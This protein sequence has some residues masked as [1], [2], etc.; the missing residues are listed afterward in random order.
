MRI[1]AA[2]D[3]LHARWEAPAERPSRH[4]G[5]DAAPP[6]EEKELPSGAGIEERSF[7]GDAAQ[8]KENS[9]G[10]GTCKSRGDPVSTAWTCL[11]LG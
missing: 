10:Q 8:H 7:L 9:L 5:G 1:W 11:V 4:R 3:R 2:L 6:R